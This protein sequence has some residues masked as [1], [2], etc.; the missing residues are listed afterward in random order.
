MGNVLASCKIGSTLWW[1]NTRCLMT[2]LCV[3]DVVVTGKQV[4]IVFKIHE[5]SIEL[6]G[7][8]QRKKVN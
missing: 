3:T 5:N 4:D 8:T 6:L 1:Q 2:A 7:R